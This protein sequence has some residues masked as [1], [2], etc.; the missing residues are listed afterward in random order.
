MVRSVVCHSTSAFVF[1]LLAIAF[2][3]VAHAVPAQ[4]SIP[5]TSPSPEVSSDVFDGPGG[6]G[7]APHPV[8]VASQA[9]EEAVRDFP[10]HQSDDGMTGTP[11]AAPVGKP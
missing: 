3:G 6:D 1:C 9:L 11:S 8:Q 5:T 7:T 4:E 10:L 2:V